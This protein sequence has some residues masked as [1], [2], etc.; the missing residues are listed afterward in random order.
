[1][2]GWVHHTSAL[3]LQHSLVSCMY[4]CY[5]DWGVAFV[6]L[7]QWHLICILL[8]ALDIPQFW[9]ASWVRTCLGWHGGVNDQK[10]LCLQTKSLL[11]YL[12]AWDKRWFFLTRT[13]SILFVLNFWFFGGGWPKTSPLGQLPF[14]VFL[15]IFWFAGWTQGPLLTVHQIGGKALQ[16]RSSHITLYPAVWVALKLPLINSLNLAA[17][18][19]IGP[20]LQ[21]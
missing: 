3:H 18:F 16:L 15:N 4:W 14:Y 6:F 8:L 2:R 19:S 5:P 11:K 20:C 12:M 17:W 10:M 9:F 1:M 21:R 7:S 13:K